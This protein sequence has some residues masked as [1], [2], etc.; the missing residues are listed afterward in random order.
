[1]RAYSAAGHTDY[2][3]VASTATRPAPGAPNLT[4]TVISS[5]RIDL[6]WTDTS[7]YE[8]GY[9]IE[10]STD[11]V[12]FTQIAAR[13]ANSTTFSN[14]GLVANSTYHYRVRAY[15]GPNDSAY[16]NVVAATTQAVA[17][18]PTNL[19]AVAIS[20]SRI[21]LS[22]TDN[23]TN[24]AGFKV[25][26][27]IDGVSF[28]QI[29]IVGA[30]VTTYSNTNLIATT[31]YHYRVRA[32]EGTNHSGYS[33]SAAATTLAPPAAPANLVATVVSSSRIDLSWTDNSTYEGGFK[34]ERSTDGV[35]FTQI[36]AYAANSTTFSNTGL[37]ANST[38]HYRVRAYD[39]PNDSAYSNVVAGST[40]A[41]AGAPTNLGAVAISSSRIVLSWTDNGTNEAGFK[42]ERGIDGVSF[43]QIAIVGANVTT[44]SNTNL[45]AATPYHYRVRAYEGTNHSGYSNS[46]AATTLAPPAAPANLVATAVSSSRI[47]LSW[48]DNSTYEGGF[49][50]ER[51]TDGMNFS[52]IATSTA[53]GTVYSNTNLLANTTYY[54]RVRAYD[55]ANHSD[56]SNAASEATLPPP[57]AP[58]N[59][60]LTVISSTRIDLRW[61]DNSTYEGG[62]KVERS[63]DG[64]NFVQITTRGANSTTYANTGLAPN[65]VYHYRVRAYEGSNHSEYSDMASAATPP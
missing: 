26:R 46:A 25:E 29:A 62:F 20:S 9:K 38:Y 41:V 12:N 30:N 39:G 56:Y 16:S 34:I 10:R 14:T 48:T 51:S 2:S 44:Y 3:N 18:A 23:G 55:G 53:N 1:V 5:S 35:N 61:V 40:Q 64:V 65:T 6:N 37:V 21:V 24:E 4:A 50:I 52:Q 58:A 22:W 43:T 59:L 13:S 31:P 28:T 54:Y 57:D 47:D 36:A 63:I 11:G 32:Y 45:I 42:V 17:G 19:G 15:D 60:V 27:G 49:K 7:T 8:S 33:N